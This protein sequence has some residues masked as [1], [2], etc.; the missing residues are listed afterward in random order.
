MMVE[1]SSVCGFGNVDERRTADTALFCG[2]S[3]R[4]GEVLEANWS[5]RLSQIL[6]HYVPVRESG[7][8]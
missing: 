7:A 5:G 4:N 3:C 6:P 1:C 2:Y 8:L